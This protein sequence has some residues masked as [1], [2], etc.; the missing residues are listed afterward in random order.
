VGTNLTIAVTLHVN[1]LTGLVE[2]LYDYRIVAN[3]YVGTQRVLNGSVNGV[4]LRF[5]YPGSTWGPNNVTIP[6]TEAN[7]GLAK[8]ESANATVTITLGDTVWI[9]GPQISLYLTEPAMQGSAGSL[10]VQNAVATT[11]TSANGQGAG[12]S[13]LPYALI[14]SGVVLVLLVVF[15]PRGHRSPQANKK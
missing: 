15:L 7:T 6:L 8:G 13:Y 4:Y 5:L 14:A 10:V 9:A 11:S 12:Q 2:Y 1:A 3:V